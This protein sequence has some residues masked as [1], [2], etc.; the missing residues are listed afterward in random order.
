MEQIPRT[1]IQ[2]PLPIRRLRAPKPFLQ[3][4]N[5]SSLIIELPRFFRWGSETTLWYLLFRLE[6]QYPPDLKTNVHQARAVG[7]PRWCHWCSDWEIF[8]KWG[9]GFQAWRNAWFIRM[10]C[11]TDRLNAEFQKNIGV[12]SGKASGHSLTEQVI[13]YMELTD[14][15]SSDWKL[16]Q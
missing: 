9:T 8:P 16:L 6:F 5:F 12:Q 2:M 7:I 10:S 3:W 14:E 1:V 13:W 15:S 11:R 4:C